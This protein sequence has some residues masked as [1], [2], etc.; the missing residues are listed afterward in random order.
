MIEVE[1]EV[2]SAQPILAVSA[3]SA[4]LA[5]LAIARLWNVIKS[6]LHHVHDS[7]LGFQQPLG[8]SCIEPILDIVDSKR[9][10]ILTALALLTLRANISLLTLVASLTYRAS[11]PSLASIALLTS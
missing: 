8:Q 6:T 4:V 10:A 11:N 3:I 1:L 5:I 9:S 2:L 7:T